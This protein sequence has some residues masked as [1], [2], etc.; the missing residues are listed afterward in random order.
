MDARH[1]T[2]KTDSETIPLDG[3][4]IRSTGK[5]FHNGSILELWQIVLS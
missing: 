4:S 1:S 2:R 3:K 5:L